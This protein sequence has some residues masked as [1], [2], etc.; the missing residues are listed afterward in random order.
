MEEKS[1]LHNKDQLYKDILAHSYTIFPKKTEEDQSTWK[2]IKLDFSIFDKDG[3]YKATFEQ[4]IPT[5]TLDQLAAQAEKRA[6]EL[7]QVQHNP[8]SPKSIKRKAFYFYEYM[9]AYHDAAANNHGIQ[10]MTKDGAIDHL[11]AE[12]PIDI[13]YLARIITHYDKVL[14]KTASEISKFVIETAL[15]EAEEILKNK[16]NF[17]F[18]PFLLE[19]ALFITPSPPPFQLQGSDLPNLE[20]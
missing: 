14:I 16:F 6:C 10:D 11:T 5:K 13:E 8:K 20:I 1:Y 18:K 4:R 2:S 7:N 15:D 3:K 9:F 12:H 19:D 17:D